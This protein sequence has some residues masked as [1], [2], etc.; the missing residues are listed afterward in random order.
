MNPQANDQGAVAAA[1]ASAYGEKVWGT[2]L[3][4]GSFLTLELGAQRPAR[5]P[6]GRP[7]GTFHLWVYC[8]AWRIETT[9]QIIA[10]SEDAREKL[11]PAVKVL[12][13]HTL[14]NAEVQ[15]PSLSATFHF[16]G[17]LVLRTFSIFSAEYDH[18]LFYLP[19]EHV[20]TAGPG[21]TVT[22]SR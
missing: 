13:G 10:S 2:T 16:D 20:L 11:E 6:T 17:G 7:H 19:D 8:S 1:L 15:W 9:Q 12:D 21:S 3:G 14:H 22:F 4:V 5:E 18:W